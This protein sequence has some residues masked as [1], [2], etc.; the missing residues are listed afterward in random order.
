MKILV[1]A[2]NISNEA[3]GYAESSFLL[4]EC[5]NK[6]KNNMVYLF[7]YWNSNNLDLNYR[8]SYKINIFKNYFLKKFPINFFVLNKINELKPDIIDIQGLWN[9]GSIFNLIYFFR[10]KKTFI[11]TPRGMLDGWSI[12]KSFIKK[13]LYYFFVERFSIK[14]A[15]CLRA[16]SQLEALN[17]KKFGFKNWIVNVP[18]GIKIPRINLKYKRKLK[19]KYRL[20]F[21]S[22]LSKKKGIKYILQAWKKIYMK[23]PR[24]E[25]VICGHDES[26]EKSRLMRLANDLELQRLEW[27]KPVFGNEK[28]LLYQSSD[29]FILPSESENFGLVVAEALAHG[30]PVITTKNTPWKDL[31]KYKCGWHI[32]L[33]LKE[34]IKT[35]EY[36][37]NL[38]PKKR[39]LMGQR[40]RKWVTKVYSENEV[41]LKMSR[42]YKW[43]LKKGPIP[44]DL[45][46]S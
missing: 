16:T 41:G 3:G 6:I 23:Y 17:L 26:N 42:V 12:K 34:I 37:I 2:S 8:L 21:L 11:I 9:S 1:L 45:I 14:N 28:K 32:K 18:N 39:F 22:R 4:R 46:V 20:L 5:L 25:L 43:A 13:I 30:V 10:K 19:K 29:I 24:W 7:G 27:K 35:L 44:R 40:G 33:D 38:S 31:K 15:F 36:S